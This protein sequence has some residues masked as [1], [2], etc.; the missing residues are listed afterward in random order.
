MYF[1]MLFIFFFLSLFPLAGKEAIH[2][3]TTYIYEKKKEGKS[4]KTTW[5][6]E[7]K[8]KTFY[9]EGTSGGGKTSIVFSYP[10]DTH[11]FSFESYDKKN[12]YS[13][14]RKGS[15]LIAKF[16]NQTRKIEKKFKIGKHLWLQEFDFSF[17]SFILSKIFSF[18]FYIIHPKKLSLHHMIATK[19]KKLEDIK[20]NNKHFRAVK[21]K[22]TL[23]GFKKIFWKAELW[24]E[25]ETGDL[26][27]YVANEGP[28]TP[29]SI[30]T[31]LSKS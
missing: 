21:V 22:V 3:K 4:H 15:Y 14:L 24:F 12:K 17:R 20:I 5:V 30:I 2:S 16:K 31:L 1:K 7:K 27:K 11:H 6:I 28:N 23:T 25:K 10:M 19:E 26:L 29:F 13:I 8:E 18:K 9:I